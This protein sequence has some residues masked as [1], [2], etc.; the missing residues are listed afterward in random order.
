[1]RLSI[2]EALRDGYDY[3]DEVVGA[4]A[5]PA[6]A[7]LA[8]LGLAA[9]AIWEGIQELAI[10]IGLQNNDHDKHLEKAA[11][12]LL[13]AGTAF[14]ISI[15][16]FIKSAISLFTRPIVTSINGYKPQNIN[17]FTIEDSIED[18]VIAFLNPSI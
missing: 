5:I 8:C 18:D 15:A 4:T 3:F 13:L 12:N 11:A 9:S 14:V 1:M 2:F 16:S 10:K 6:L 7:G 17:R